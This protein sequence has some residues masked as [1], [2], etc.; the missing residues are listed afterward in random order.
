MIMLFSR[1]TLLPW[2][3]LLLVFGLAGCGEGKVV[4]VSG[5]LTYKGQPVPNAYI[6]FSPDNG[7]PSWGVTDEQGRFTLH[8]D[9][10]QDGATVGKHKVSAKLN[11]TAANATEPGMPP[12]VP[13]EWA[14]FFDKYGEKS[15]VEVVIDRSTNDLRL[16]WD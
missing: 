13:K 1:T 10:S 15:K 2:A 12:K 3:V 5:T 8:Y 7:R 9:R 4:K 16:D 6:G 14:A 11:P